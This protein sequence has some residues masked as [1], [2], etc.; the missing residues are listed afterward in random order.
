MSGEAQGATYTVA[1]IDDMPFEE[2]SSPGTEW[3]PVRRIFSIGS[4]GTALA[5]ANKA[6]DTL[7]HDHDEVT[8]RHEELFLI[9]S[10]HATYR[11]DGEEIDAPAGT[12][13]YTPDPATVRGVVAR[14]AGTVM[15]V[16][17]GEP[18]AVFTPS[19]WDTEPLPG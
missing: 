13:L 15:L 18:G 12:F 10:G 2:G 17:G 11:V 7:T 5:R 4:F 3:K 6:G 19:D 1:H 14:E 16:V 8:T 9:V